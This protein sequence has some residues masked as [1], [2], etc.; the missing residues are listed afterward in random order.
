MFRLLLTVFAA[1][2][3][4]ACSAPSEPGGDA[5]APVETAGGGAP[6][7]ADCGGLSGIM[8]AGAADETAFCKYTPEQSC[9]AADQMGVCTARPEICPDVYDPVCGCDGETYGNACEADSAGVSIVYE[10]VCRA[11]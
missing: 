6:I 10:S 11:G 5:E 7:G 4:T 1:L 8:C 2:T 9:G 3:I